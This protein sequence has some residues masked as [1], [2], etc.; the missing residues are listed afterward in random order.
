MILLIEAGGIRSS[1]FLSNST[2]PVS[3][4]MISA[5]FASVSSAAPGARGAAGA[6]GDFGLAGPDAGLAGATGLVCAATT[7]PAPASD[8]IIAAATLIAMPPR[9]R[10]P[11][12]PLRPSRRGILVDNDVGVSVAALDHLRKCAIGCFLGIDRSDLHPIER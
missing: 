7:T 12:I 3:T 8:T 1:P 11:I 5:C 9:Q 10:P 6:A 4:S 2:V